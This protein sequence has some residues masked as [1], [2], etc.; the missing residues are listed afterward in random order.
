MESNLKQYIDELISE[1]QN[2]LDEA[3][4]TGNVAG[5]NT[6]N[7]FSDKGASDKNRKKKMAKRIGYTL[8]GKI[9]ESFM[10]DLD[11]IKKGSKDITDFIK[12]VLSNKDYKEVRTDKEFHKYLKSFYNESVVSE[13]YKG[14]ISDF[15]TD[16]SLALDNVGISPKAI[17]KISKKGKGFELR[18]S[19]YMKDKNTWEKLGKEMGAKLVD[20]QPGS[21]NIGLYESVNEEKL[22]PK[23]LT[24]LKKGEKFVFNNTPYE[25]VELYTDINNAAKVKTQDGKTSVVSFGGGMVNKNTKGGFG[26]YLKQGGRV[27]DNVNPTDSPSITENADYKYLTQTILDAKPKY[28]VYYN[29]GHNKVNIGGVGYDGGD[30]VKN[31][32]QKPGSSS[33]IKNNFYHADQDPHKTKKEVEKLSNGKIKVDIQK[34]YGGK[35]MAVYIMK[36]SVN[37]ESYKVAGRPVTLIKGKK[38][39][40]TDWKVK[41]QNGKETSLSDVL[42]LIKPFPK[43]IKESVIDEVIDK[44]DL[45][46][47]KDRLKYPHTIED[48]EYRTTRRGDKFVKIIYKKKYVPGKMMD[49]GPHFVSVFYTDE[50]DLQNIGKALKLKLKESVNENLITERQLKGLEGIDNKTPL[51]KISD[52]QKLKIIQGTGNNISFK[53]P[54]GFDRNFWQV[55]SK[56]KIKKK[57]S[58]SGDI[59]YFLPGKIINSPNFKS[60]KDLIN[61]VDWVAVEQTRRFNESVVNEGVLDIFKNEFKI[62][63]N[64][65]KKTFGGSG[66]KISVKHIRPDIKYTDKY[67][68]VLGPNGN[69]IRIQVSAYQ[70]GWSEKVPASS[71]L[72]PDFTDKKYGGSWSV[73]AYKKDSRDEM[74]TTKISS[75]TNQEYSVSI[76]SNR[77]AKKWVLGQLTKYISSHKD[78]LKKFIT[79]PISESVNEAKIKRPV[80][81]WLELKNDETMHPHKKMAH[82]LKELKYQ[83]AETE[84]FFKW[85]NKIKN[86]N[87]LES[88]NYWKRTQNHIYKI[89]ERLVNIARTIQEIE[90]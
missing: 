19:S 69:S 62:A 24:Q 35:P 7:A 72:F 44:D 13:S 5:Y 90:K 39:D 6:P 86:I 38:M 82:G 64:F 42:S 57:K 14:T 58:L 41:F 70:T 16:I 8:A 29:S 54:K 53:V 65:I 79:E 75:K 15:K 60:E 10:S 74:D 43:N 84:K 34:G 89:K 77:D 56:G 21:I 33:K 49:T 25:F 47:A 48:I 68:E 23:K 3:T 88:S 87:E 27:W 55:F 18:M 83:L 20:F 81:R 30:L 67:I 28:N 11:I 61:G 37:E 63:L 4:A 17:K 66:V 51:T 40:G 50:K 2:E 46:N 1:I 76:K 80:N 78:I 59:V 26:D 73:K 32:N 9:D 52:A 12:K 31:F 45:K 71:A 22:K 85:Y 36:E